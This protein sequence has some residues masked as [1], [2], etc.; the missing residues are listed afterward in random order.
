VCRICRLKTSFTINVLETRTDQNSFFHREPSRERW[1]ILSRRHRPIVGSLAFN[2]RQNSGTDWPEFLPLERRDGSFLYNIYTSRYKWRGFAM[3]ANQIHLSNV[4]YNAWVWY[5]D[6]YYGS[7]YLSLYLDI[8]RKERVARDWNTR[9]QDSIDLFISIVY[10]RSR[11]KN[12][13]ELNRFV[14]RAMEKYRVDDLA[15]LQ[16]TKV[17]L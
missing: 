10:L 6:I 3:L 9:Y 8:Y 16:L 7:C 5:T 14:K 15:K 1:I 12:L 17:H 2:H 4:T 11:L 13:Y